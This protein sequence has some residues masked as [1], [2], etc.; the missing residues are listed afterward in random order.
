[1]YFSATGNTKY[2]AEFISSKLNDGSIVSINDMMKNGVREIDCT[3]QKR[4]GIFAP[5]YDFSMAYAVSEFLAGV[6]FRNVDDDCYI[7]GVFTCGSACGDCTGKLKD[8]LTAKGL[9]L[10]AGFVVIMPDNYVLMFPQKTDDAKRRTLEHSDNILNEI[11][12]EISENR[13]V[14]R[15]KGKAPRF[16]ASL[17]N[18]LM[19]PSQRKVKGFTVSNNCIG[20]GLCVK[21]CPMNIIEL[22]N[23]RP[24]WTKDNCA[25]CLACLHRCPQKA[26]NRG[27][28]AK[29]GRYI[30]PNV[31]I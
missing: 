20:C 30:N 18:K 31:K 16:L 17:I 28:S 11:T 6:E 24:V 27:K 3:G 26:I 22:R 29:N 25:C 7:Y 21:V 12:A 14:F 23:N 2:C 19:V 13:H 15:L 9:R 5:V 10:D 1:M 4:L 8:I